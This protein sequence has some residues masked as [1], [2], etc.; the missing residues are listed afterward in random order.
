MVKI[1]MRKP[2]LKSSFKA[3]TTGRAKRAVKRA[4]IPGYGK[5]GMGWIKNPR[6][7]AYNAVYHRTTVGVGDVARAIAKPSRRKSASGARSA[8]PAAPRAAAG[9]AASR[10]LVQSMTSLGQLDWALLLCLFLGWTGAHRAYARMWGSFLL[11][12]F[13]FGLFGFG[14]LFDFVTLIM[15]RSE[16][17]RL[18]GS[19]PAAHEALCPAGFVSDEDARESDDWERRTEEEVAARLELQRKNRAYMEENGVDIGMFNEE[20]VMAD[21]LRTIESMCPCVLKFDRGMSREE[22]SISFCSP[23]KTGKLPK[24]VVEAHVY[25]QD[26]KTVRD[27]HGF[28]WQRYGDSINVK[29]SYLSDGRI[30]K[31]DVRGFHKT[32]SVSVSIRRRGDDLVMT[33][34]G[35]VGETGAWQSLC[36]G[37]DP[38]AG[39]LLEALNREVERIY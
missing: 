16:L 7:A 15:R 27:S 17:K 23:T 36:P 19:V 31:F 9:G 35:T 3:R 29:I 13:T 24:N 39:D 1:G 30:N 12:L 6:K 21:A 18:G 8:A 32:R 5:K 2:N 33:S 37:A 20:K 22:P 28:E 14:W 10:T 4:I 34:A 26:V 25:H 38:S 11:Y